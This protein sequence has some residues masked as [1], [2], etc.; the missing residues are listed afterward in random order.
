M[1]TRRHVI[2]T[3]MVLG[4]VSWPQVKAEDSD[5][6]LTKAVS[7]YRGR[8]V[9]LLTDTPLA[10]ALV[11][12]AWPRRSDSGHGPPHR[13]HA[14]RE[15]VTDA[16]GIFTIDAA[17]IEASAPAD[18]LAPRMLAW[19]P[20]YISLP[21][22]YGA[23]FGVPVAWLAQRGGIIALKPATGLEERVMAF[24]VAYMSV[25]ERQTSRR[26]IDLPL[27]MHMAREEVAFFS[28]NGKE[29]ETHLRGSP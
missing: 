5:P 7:L 17:D 8:V 13:T 3:A 21:R 4:L 16:N 9:E 20:G 14:L 29:I 2:I 28:R 26:A 25:E 24:N 1:N 15:T 23:R 19:K 10:G 27:L 18:A 11:V 12:F 6:P 22:E